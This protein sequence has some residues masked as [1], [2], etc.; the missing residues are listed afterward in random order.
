MLKLFKYFLWLVVIAALMIGFDR[1]MV[2]VPLKAPGLSETQVFY[3]DFRSRLFNLFGENQRTQQDKIEKVIEKSAK[4]DP[5][6]MKK[7][8][9]YLYVDDN[10]ALQF[11]DSLQQVPFK[12][13]HN[14]QP[15]AE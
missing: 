5:Q 2:L 1:L 8:T 7:T 3:T 4:L 11:A 6:T 15:L 9:R 14:A 12:Y 13:R 10:G